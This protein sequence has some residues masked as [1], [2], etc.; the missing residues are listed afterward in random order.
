[1]SLAVRSRLDAQAVHL[2]SASRTLIHPESLIETCV[3]YGL[4]PENFDLTFQGTVTVRR[5]LQMC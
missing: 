3:R 5:A 1:M 4:A 2:W